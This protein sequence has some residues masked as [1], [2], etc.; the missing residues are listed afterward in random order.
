MT[1]CI[2]LVVAIALPLL[3]VACSQKESE[4]SAR[5][6]IYLSQF[7]VAD[8][9]AMQRSAVALNHTAERF[10]S[11]PVEENY[12][13]L[14]QGWRQA[15]SAWQSVEAVSQLYLEENM[16][17]WRFQF[18]PDKKNLTGRKIEALLKKS[19]SSDLREESVIV[20]GLSALEYLLFDPTNGQRILLGEEN[21]CRLLKVVSNTL[22]LNAGD[23][24]DR[25]QANG[26]FYNEYFSS[27]PEKQVTV[28][29][30]VLNSLDVLSSRLIREVGLPMG[31]QKVNHYLAESW[32]SKQ[33]LE[34]IQQSLTTGLKMTQFVLT[35]SLSG[36]ERAIWQGLAEDIAQFNQDMEPLPAS[37][38]GL[39]EE[40][41]RDR[42]VALHRDL[43]EL[44]GGVRKA[45]VALKIPLGFNT[46]D[47]D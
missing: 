38:P 33:S 12:L 45:S 28:P 42:L 43:S 14:R 41:G 37:I 31:K 22:V 29:V 17:G 30:L 21:R 7:I 26:A 10:C 1:R 8:Y 19:V 23:L 3:L 46:N 4:E 13:S 36:Q 18:W 39:V 27:E 44:R 5:K 40:Q 9:A 2:R 25:W 15:M 34:N 32:R 24:K 20:Q 6:E 47:G 16:E 35:G 11:S